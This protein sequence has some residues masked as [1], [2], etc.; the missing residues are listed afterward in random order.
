MP[1]HLELDVHYGATANPCTLVLRGS[2]VSLGSPGVCFSSVLSDKTPLATSPSC[3]RG[4][5]HS[6]PLARPEKGRCSGR[7]GR[8]VLAHR[9][10]G[11]GRPS[12]EW[13]LEVELVLGSASA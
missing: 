3:L 2:G 6:L 13:E 11:P 5:R 4:K 8:A 12:V 1:G 7:P 9:V 10:Q